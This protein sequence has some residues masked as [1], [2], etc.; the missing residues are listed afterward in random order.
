MEKQHIKRQIRHWGMAWV[1][2]GLVWACAKDGLETAGGAQAGSRL[3][4]Y[5]EQVT[6]RAAQPDQGFEEGVKYRIWVTQPRDTA[7][8]MTDGGDGYEGTEALREDGTHYI[9]LRPIEASGEGIINQDFYGFTSAD[10]TVP[11]AKA[12]NDAYSITREENADY[13]DYLRGELKYPYSGSETTGGILQ[14]PFKHILSQVCLQASKSTE[15]EGVIEIVSVEL[16]GSSDGKERIAKSGSYC[17]YENIFK[18]EEKENRK[19]ELEDPLALP[20]DGTAKAIDTI[21]IFPTF[22]S[23]EQ[24]TA[25]KAGQTYLRVTFK[26]PDDCYKNFDKGE[27]GTKSIT[28]PINDAGTGE[29]L[30]F[31]QN[32]SYTLQMTFMSDQQRIVMLVPQ[33]LNWL[34]KEG[35]PATGWTTAEDLGQPVTFNGLLWSDRNLGATSGNPTRSVDDWYNSLGYIYQYGRNIPYYPFEA[36]NPGNGKVEINYNTTARDAFTKDDKTVY[37]LLNMESWGLKAEDLANNNNGKGWWVNPTTT[38]TALVWD[39][40]VDRLNK[41]Q[42]AY[43]FGDFGYYNGENYQLNLLKGYDG[44]WANN[45]NTPC[46]PGW[47]LPT[48]TEFMSILPSSGFAGNIT[49]RR[50]DGKVESNGD[51]T[52]I[53]NQ[54]AEPNFESA[55]SKDSIGEMT[56]TPSSK[57]P[58]YKGFYPYVYREETDDFHDGSNIRGQ[59]VLSMAEGDRTQ[60]KNNNRWLGRNTNYNFNWGVIYGIKNQG[61][62]RAY[63]MKWSIRLMTDEVPKTDQEVDGSQSLVYL[64]NPFRGIL[65][66]ERF[67]ASQEDK[68]VPDRNGSYEAS[69]RSYDWEHPVA[70]MYLP[71]GGCCDAEWFKGKIGNVGSEVWYATSELSET[72]GRKKIVWIKFAGSN[73]RSSQTITTS[74]RSQLGAAVFIRPVRDF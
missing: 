26:D 36:A 63:R 74:D 51:W 62:A 21:L 55:F 24:E 17:V 46:P 19:I 11:E 43:K 67:M 8:D 50:F 45:T 23:E 73:S 13:T 47:R 12:V 60:V 16:M 70:V 3:S 44:D 39:L 58:A 27:N 48:L 71:V 42:E 20:E 68:F 61:T 52:T 4:A 49:F 33:V 6:T 32:H 28:L 2:A 30:V 5:R 57:T 66:I 37:P 41:L 7:P 64:N 10:K 53:D 65:V 35:S 34:E 56:E 38:R 72:N 14:M 9:Y 40:N 59:Y 22:E 1:C 18:I 15:V 25:L 31:R 54:D 29:P 69:V